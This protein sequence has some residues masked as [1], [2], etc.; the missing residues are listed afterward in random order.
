MK[1]N[2]PS[3]GQMPQ[4]GTGW[5]LVNAK[6]AKFYI[7]T[8]F[9]ETHDWRCQDTSKWN[10]DSDIT[11]GLRIETDQVLSWIEID[12]IKTN[13]ELDEN[14]EEYPSLF[15]E[16]CR[17]EVADYSEYD[18]KFT[19]RYG[20]KVTAICRMAERAYKLMGYMRDITPVDITVIN[21]VIR[22]VKPHKQ[23]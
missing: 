8:Y 3:K 23:E 16:N 19:F 11:K 15:Y 9:P 20:G 5:C 13:L 21:G 12:A 10:G 2:Y 6:N 17:L 22:D 7:A 14:G 1:W 18:S 4:R